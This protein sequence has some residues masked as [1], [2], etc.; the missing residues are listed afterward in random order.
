MK[1]KINENRPLAFCV[2]VLVV[3]L[4][5]VF[6]GGGGLRALRGEALE[7]F[8][9]GVNGDG[10]CVYTDLQERADCAFNLAALAQRYDEIPQEITQKAAEAAQELSDVPDDETAAM[11][12]ANETLGRAVEALYTELENTQL[13]EADATYALSQYK[14]FTSRGLTISRDGYNALAEEFNR[15]IGVFPA[16]IV[17]MLSGVGQLTL[18]R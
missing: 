14:E 9:V 4:S 7:A 10:L 8:H 15:T 3:V 12:R 11:Q 13:T 5:I 18:F 6:S 2:L 1:N 17:A 16:N